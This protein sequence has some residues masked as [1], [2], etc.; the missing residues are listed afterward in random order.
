MMPTTPRLG[1]LFALMEVYAVAAKAQGNKRG[2]TATPK[3]RNR[4]W[5]W[6]SA[7]RTCFS[8]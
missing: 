8:L 6:N 4:G 1:M 5:P 7:G 3:K 2:D